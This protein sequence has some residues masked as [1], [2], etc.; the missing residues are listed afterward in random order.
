M[1]I[2]KLEKWMN[3]IARQQIL[4]SPDD[5]QKSL[6]LFRAALEVIKDQNYRG[7]K[8]ATYQP[9]NNFLNTIEKEL[10]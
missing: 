5:L 10:G 7:W 9:Y 4:T 6:R 3:N 2:G 1:S 8:M